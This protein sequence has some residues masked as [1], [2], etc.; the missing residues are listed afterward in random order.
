MNEQLIIEAIVASVNHTTVKMD[1]I[2]TLAAE[3]SKFSIYAFA[4]P[5]S[6][7]AIQR[8]NIR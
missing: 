5:I 2:S 6:V 7:G 3:L 4:A 8:T 1:S